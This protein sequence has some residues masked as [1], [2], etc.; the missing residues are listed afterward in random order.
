MTA[1]TLVYCFATLKKVEVL[2]LQ[3]SRPYRSHLTPLCEHA[4]LLA[5]SH[6]RLFFLP[7]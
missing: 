1:E 3:L 5:A 6:W 2:V 7:S 4:V